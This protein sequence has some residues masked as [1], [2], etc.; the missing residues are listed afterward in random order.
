MNPMRTRRSPN[1]PMPL[2]RVCELC[3]KA[4]GTTPIALHGYW[5]PR[6]WRKASDIVKQI[7]GGKIA[8]E[9]ARLRLL[10]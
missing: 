2:P 5:H 7:I 8:E 4:G 10:P 3:G 9:R 1:R 6:C